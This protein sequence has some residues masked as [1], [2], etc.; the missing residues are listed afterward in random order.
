MACG[1]SAVCRVGKA[2]SG[3]SL[4]LKDVLILSFAFVFLKA[5][6]R[7]LSS[8]TVLTVYCPWL[9]QSGGLRDSGL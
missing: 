4:T 3:T 7:A 9:G 5:R 1:H 8:C 2:R 6:E